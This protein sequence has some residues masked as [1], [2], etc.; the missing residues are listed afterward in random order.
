MNL[1][2]CFLVLVHAGISGMAYWLLFYTAVTVSL[3]HAA[4]ILPVLVEDMSTSTFLFQKN[5]W[6]RFM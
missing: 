4:S 5:H 2:Q 6:P 3:R 1:Y